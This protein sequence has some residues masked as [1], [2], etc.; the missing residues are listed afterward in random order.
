M[1]VGGKAIIATGR[2]CGTSITMGS[3]GVITVNDGLSFSTSGI[4]STK[5]GLI[6]PNTV[7]IRARL[8]VPF[9][10]AISTSDCLTNAETT[11]YNNMAAIFS[12]PMRRDNRA[13][14]KLVGSGGR[15]LRGRTYI[16]CTFRY[17]VASL[18]N[19]RVLSRV[20][21]TMGRN[22]ADFGYFFMCGGRR[23]VISSTAFMELLLETGRLNTGV[24]LRTRG[25][26]L[27]SVEA[28][29]FLGRNGADT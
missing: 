14:V 2:D 21:A 4:I 6:L 10:N 16:S 19:N 11:T 25:P 29:R 9:N 5:K 27:V 3:N 15:I 17:Y 26:S 13:V 23:V 1:L 20:R 28:R 22:V 18:G 8:T 24:G 12:C 7:S